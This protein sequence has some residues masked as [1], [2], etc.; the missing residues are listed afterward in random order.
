MAKVLVNGKFGVTELRLPQNVEVK[1]QDLTW[2]A[3]TQLEN[4]MF[5]TVDA[6]TGEMA[7][8]KDGDDAY[9][10][11]AVPKLYEGHLSASDYVMTPE[12]FFPRVI[13][14]GKGSIIATD[15]VVVD[16]AVFADFN[17]IETFLAT[18][19]NKAY[20]II[21]ATGRMAITKTAPTEGVAFEVAKVTTLKTGEQGVELVRI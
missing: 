11:H 4:G 17:A 3:L 2:G 12:G 1:V 14:L 9:Y 20:G 13:R 6:K 7:L 18:K 19:A 21:D 16:T 15:N 8:A 5:V 10:V